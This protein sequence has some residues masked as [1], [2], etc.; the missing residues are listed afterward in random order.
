MTYKKI[1]II[2]LPRSGTT[3]I[4]AAMLELGYNVAHTAYTQKAFDNACV[5]ADTPIFAD[6]KQL[7]SFYPNSKFIYLSRDSDKW[8]PSIKQ[9]LQRMYVNVTRVD[10]G[11]NTIIK[12]CYRKTF[13]PF[14]L[15]NI[16]DD[17]FL[18]RCY[19]QHMNEVNQ[20]FAERAQDLLTIDIS[21]PTSYAKLLSF[22]SLRDIN[23]QGCFER[24]N[25]GGK[26]TA[27]K[28]LKHDKK[29][30]STKNGRMSLLDYSVLLEKE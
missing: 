22:L 30:E 10:G 20:Y 19:L 16:E 8:I 24:M 11:F 12:R 29:V 25:S 1:F 15:E 14:T 18:A 26:V 9:L 23:K 13:A 5:I 27:W 6:Y 28:D 21:E 7:D 17:D 2:G 3:S 4:C